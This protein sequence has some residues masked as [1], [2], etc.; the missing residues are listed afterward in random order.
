MKHLKFALLGELAAPATVSVKDFKG[1]PRDR[2]EIIQR[3]HGQSSVQAGITPSLHV[4]VL[5]PL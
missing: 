1:I 5:L 2:P 3:T 4:I